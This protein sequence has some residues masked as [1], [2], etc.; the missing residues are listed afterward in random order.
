MGGRELIALSIGM[1][2]C[3]PSN[4]LESYSE[5]AGTSGPPPFSADGLA[6]DVDEG[7]PEQAAAPAPAGPAEDGEPSLD[8][9]LPP[10]PTSLD[11]GGGPGTSGS[12][13]ADPGSLEPSS[14]EPS[15]LEPS[16]G[17]E[18]TDDSGVE[19]GGAEP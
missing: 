3:L 4:A 9:E 7:A 14:L 15:S 13:G 11:L 19:P 6:P 16:E 2:A 12:S 8:S 1:L 5:S 18:G 10:L 17:D